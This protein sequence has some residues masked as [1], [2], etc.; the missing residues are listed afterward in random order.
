MASHWNQCMYEVL[1]TDTEYK[2][3]HLRMALMRT[4]THPCARRG[5]SAYGPATTRRIA[6]YE[7]SWSGEQQ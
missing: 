2:H 6:G 7:F 1:R 5:G 4:G 3:V